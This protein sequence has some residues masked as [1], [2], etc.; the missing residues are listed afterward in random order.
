MARPAP[1]P[2][3]VISTGSTARNDDRRPGHEEIIMATETLSL[4]EFIRELLFNDELRQDFSRDP[5]GTL[6]DHGLDDLSPEDVHDA[7]VLVEDNQTAD[8]SRD[9]NT[10]SNAVALTPPPPVE[11]SGDGASSHQEAVQYLNNYVTNN[12]IDD[13]DTITDNSINQQ[14]DTDGG[15]FDQDIDVDSVVASGDGA[16]AAGEDIEDSTIVTGDDNQVGDGNVRGD[17]NIV[18]DDNDGNL[19]GDGD[20][21]VVGDDNNA[22]T[23]D[24]NTTGF[25]SGD[26]TDVD[27]DGDLSADDGSSIAIGGNSSVDN[28]DNSTND[29]FNDSS[30]NSVNDSGNT[31]V[32]VEVEDSFND[33]SDN[34]VEDS[35]NDNSKNT[36]DNSTT[37]DA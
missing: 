37:L 21:N 20:G 26:V 12:F 3:F 29:S 28:S 34:S 33:N 35:F 32:D 22:V 11:H 4:L 16:V 14:I 9:F 15:D 23:G 31:A 8:F 25:G 17:G 36:V 19:V 5:E 6:A 18:G 10:G 30:D 2:N 1:L 7:L 24:G 27:V 13:R